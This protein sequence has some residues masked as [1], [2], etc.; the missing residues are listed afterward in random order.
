MGEK[1]IGKVSDYFEHVQVIAMT[2][3]APLKIGDTIQIKGGEVDFEQK[4]ESMQIDRKPVTSAKKGD[5]V[6]IKISEKARK[7]YKVY[8]KE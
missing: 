7:G 6:G 1:E 2:L 4:I 3:S 8:K 5:T